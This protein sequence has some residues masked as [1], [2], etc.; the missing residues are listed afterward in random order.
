MKLFKTLREIYD[1]LVTKLTFGFN[2]SKNPVI[3][4]QQAIDKLEKSYNNCKNIFMTMET[5][6]LDI[7]R[8]I[9]TAT[10]QRESLR[11]DLIAMRENKDSNKDMLAAKMGS[12]EI[13]A[14]NVESWKARLEKLETSQAR[15]LTQKDGLKDKIEILT[16]KRDDYETQLQINEATELSTGA[17]GAGFDGD[18]IAKMLKEADEQMNYFNDKSS[19]KLATHEAFDSEEEDKLGEELFGKKMSDQELEEKLA[20][21]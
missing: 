4:T 12:Y 21:L 13:K 9:N 19:A 20:K 15:L 10:E 1:Y 5:N 7:E 8:K 6:R 17:Y 16:I 14:K 18:A 11:N 3:V 2:K